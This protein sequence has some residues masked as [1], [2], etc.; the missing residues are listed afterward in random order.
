VHRVRREGVELAFLDEG[1]GPAV[2]LLHGFP[3][4]SQLW[5]K[6]VPALVDAGLRVVAP[7]LRGF[8]ESG[9]PEEV[10]EYRITR[11]VADVV[12]ILDARGID[13]A[14]VVGHDFGASVAWAIAG[15]APDRVE[16]LT[17]MSVGHPN[18]QSPSIEQ[19][20]K[21]WYTLLFQFEGVAEELLA[22]DDWALLRDWMR[23]DGDMERAIEAFREPGALTAALNWYRANTPPGREL[24]PKRPFPKIAA[25]TLGLWSDGDRYLL[26]EP[27]RSS[28]AEVTGRW[29]YER[30]AGASHWLQL[31]SAEQ[32]NALLLEHMLGDSF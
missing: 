29:R 31:D 14:H 26:E 23:N 3:D 17:A 20:E 9:R 28:G 16:R 11:S 12:A 22:R 2:V 27:I 18:R 1:E 25:T 30:I 15:L 4:S 32:V 5:R 19:R 10:E 6:Q 13:R 24:A 8:G 7:D 21:S